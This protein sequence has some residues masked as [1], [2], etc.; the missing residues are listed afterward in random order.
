MPIIRI[1]RLC[2]AAQKCR[3]LG[4]IVYSCDAYLPSYKQMLY[5]S[6]PESEGGQIALVKDIYQVSYSTASGKHGSTTV[7]CVCLLKEHKYKD[8]YGGYVQLWSTYIAQKCY[9]PLSRI[10][11]YCAFIKVDNLDVADPNAPHCRFAVIPL[12]QNS[13]RLSVIS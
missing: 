2:V 1:D 10:I 6:V 9:L 7:L 4:S 12:L 8:F 3:H 5:V 11:C 13:A